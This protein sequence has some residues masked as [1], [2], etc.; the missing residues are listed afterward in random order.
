MSNKNKSLTEAHKRLDKTQTPQMTWLEPDQDQVNQDPVQAPLEGSYVVQEDNFKVS[1]RIENSP[2]QKPG[3]LNSATAGDHILRPAKNLDPDKTIPDA[4]I[5]IRE[6]VT[7]F[8]QG[9]PMTGQRVPVYNGEDDQFPDLDKMDLAERQ[10]YLENAVN[11]LEMLTERITKAN[12]DPDL[13]IPL[14]RSDK[15]PNQGSQAL[16]TSPTDADQGAKGDQGPLP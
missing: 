11:E 7:R 10:E 16:G 14:Y 5:S 2:G 3:F 15:K 13:Q 1:E 8:A 4:T 9:L 12:V 6:L